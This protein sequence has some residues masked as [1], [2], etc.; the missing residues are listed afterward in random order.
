MRQRNAIRARI[1]VI[2][3]LSV[4]FRL[5]ANHNMWGSSQLFKINTIIGIIQFVSIH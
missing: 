2:I 1:V 5:Y 4:K 3:Y